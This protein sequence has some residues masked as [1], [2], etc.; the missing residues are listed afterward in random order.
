M[1]MP[2]PPVS[3]WR[4]KQTASADQLKYAGTKARMDRTCKDPIQS[5]GPQAIV[6]CGVGEVVVVVDMLNLRLWESR[7]ET[8]TR[9]ADRSVVSRIARRVRKARPPRSLAPAFLRQSPP[10]SSNSL[11]WTARVS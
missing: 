10:R 2:M 6:V 5:T 9:W 4:K 7:A 1:Q 11:Q 3:Q 8:T